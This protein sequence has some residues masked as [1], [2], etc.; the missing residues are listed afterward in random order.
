MCDQGRSTSI[1]HKPISPLMT[2][3]L[4]KWVQKTHTHTPVLTFATVRWLEQIENNGGLIVIYPMGS[5]PRTSWW[6]NQPIW[7]ICSSNWIISPG[8]VENKQKYLSWHHLVKK[9]TCKTN[10]NV[11]FQ[12]SPT[13]IV[14]IQVRK[15]P[16]PQTVVIQLQKI[17]SYSIFHHLIFTWQ[18]LGPLLKGDNS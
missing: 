17:T 15:S 18:P 2:G 14:I 5:N 3:I 6:L 13:W 8:R 1:G 9:I 11:S 12:T 7:K 10:T 4:I 16:W